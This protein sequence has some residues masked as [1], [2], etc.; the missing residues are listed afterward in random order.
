MCNLAMK[1]GKIMGE[2]GLHL[3]NGNVIRHQAPEERCKYLELMEA[4]D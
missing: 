3:M 2:N 4:S 1:G